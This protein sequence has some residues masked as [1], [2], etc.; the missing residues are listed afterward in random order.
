MANV[1]LSQIAAGSPLQESGATDQH[2]VV[3]SGTTD[4]LV[5][6][7]SLSHYN[8]QAY[9]VLP[10]NSAATNVTNFQALVNSTQSI[11]GVVW[12]FPKGVYNFNG[13]ITLGGAAS[14]TIYGDGN[15][16]GNS[17]GGT[18]LFSQF[19]GTMLSV[20]YGGGSGRCVIKDL[21]LVNK[22]PAGGCLYMHNANEPLISNVTCSG[23]RGTVYS[24]YTNT[25]NT[26]IQSQSFSECYVMTSYDSLG[27]GWAV[28]S[29]GGGCALHSSDAETCGIAF[30][31]QGTGCGF[32]GTRCEVSG[33]A[34]N[35]GMD[36]TQSI[37][38]LNACTLL[39]ASLEGNIVGIALRNVGT[40]NINGVQCKMENSSPGNTH[41]G[42]YLGNADNTV[43]IQNS[44]FAGS[45]Q[46]ASIGQ[47][48]NS[49]ITAMTFENIRTSNSFGTPQTG[50]T[51]DISDNPDIFTFIGCTDYKPRSDDVFSPMMRVG[52]VGFNAIQQNNLTAPCVQGRN[53]RNVNW[54]V[55][56][57]ATSAAVLFNVSIGSGSIDITPTQTTGGSLTLLGTYKVQ[58]TAVCPLGEVAGIEH[59]VVLT[60][61]NNA[62]TC[63]GSNISVPGIFRR[64][65][66]ICEVSSANTDFFGINPYA[67]FFESIMND[68]SPLT[69]TALPNT[70]NLASPP[71]TGTNETSMQE[72]D[73]NYYSNPSGSWSGHGA[74][75]P[76]NGKLKTGV[77]VGFAAAA[78]APIVTGSVSTASNAT[79]IK[80]TTS[81]IHGLQ[82]GQTVTIAGSSDTNAN[83]TAVVTVIDLLNFT[84]TGTT[85]DGGGTGGT[86][87]LSNAIT[88]GTGV[89]GGAI[90][91]TTGTNHGLVTGQCVSIAGMGGLTQAN[92]TNWQVQ[93][94][95]PTTFVPIAAKA[96]SSAYTSG[97]TWAPGPSVD[98]GY[99]R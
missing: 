19:S 76:P 84:L 35:L 59:T 97:G 86:W 14:F 39:N 63:T 87:T 82:T 29:G 62:I 38:Q 92:G 33:I 98:V 7:A 96:G 47:A 34:Y 27:I 2:L 1:K 61:S 13:T 69:L 65:Y 40:T 57:G 66:Y 85:A 42:L 56:V 15:A 75:I 95:S 12:Y 18:S 4:N 90:T 53:V 26:G 55:Q 28:E 11:I 51:W 48:P 79:P 58:C 23:G 8:V 6:T 44:T 83:T 49:L 88:N 10:A 32:F 52:N 94:L 45:A 73:I 9:G 54:P 78:T 17:S 60:G 64:R 20:D 72:P 67:G 24:G 43:V 31:G 89:N 71:P 5:N 91:I 74:Y 41:Y 36:F 68:N 22:D 3:R 37:S 21:Q 30:Q 93:V 80:I 25:T 46:F 50:K 16:A 77:L 70:T 99:L 81:A